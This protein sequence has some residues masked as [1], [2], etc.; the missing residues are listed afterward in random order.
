MAKERKTVK[1]ANEAQGEQAK[2]ID[3]KSIYAFDPKDITTDVSVVRY[4][5]LAYIQ[6]MPRDLYIDFL[7][8]PGVK[9]DGK[10]VA[11]GTRIYMSHT[12][13][14]K[15][16]EVL[17]GILKQVSLSGGME[18]YEDKRKSVRPG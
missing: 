10:M 11:T 18:K 14:Q 13:G 16:A 17:A 5:N 6:V 4:S 15:L 8:M 2:S 7:E 9:K 1:K 3:L 12:A